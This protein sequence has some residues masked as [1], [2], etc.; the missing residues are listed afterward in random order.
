MIEEALQ[1]LKAEFR[2]PLQ[3]ECAVARESW[4]MP[5]A[6]GTWDIADIYREVKMHAS[7]G[8]MASLLKMAKALP[9]ARLAVGDKNVYLLSQ[10]NLLITGAMPLAASE[11]WSALMRLTA[12]QPLEI[13]RE[14][15]TTELDGHIEETLAMNLERVVLSSSKKNEFRIGASGLSE[16][17]R[18][19]AFALSFNGD[20]E[21]GA[22]NVR[23]RED[24]SFSGRMWSCW[25][26]GK[27]NVAL[28]LRIAVKDDAL[29]LRFATVKLASVCEEARASLVN[30]LGTE[31]LDAFSGSVERTFK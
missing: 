19:K 22:I 8:D 6:D 10:S 29:Q 24:W 15:L 18:D 21:A 16:S 20:G 12:F 7:L 14:V 4:A 27:F 30:Y 9:D 11:E 5:N 23:L 17:S 13:F 1:M 28:K 3:I 26:D 25:P 31:G 2:K